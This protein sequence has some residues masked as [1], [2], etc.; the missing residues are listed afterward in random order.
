MK[1]VI[2]QIILMTLIASLL[3]ACSDGGTSTSAAPESIPRTPIS[4]EDFVLTQQNSL[5]VNGE[6]Q[7]NVQLNNLAADDV[8][9]VTA[10]SDDA[11]NGKLTLTPF[12]TILNPND[13]SASFVL[14]VKDLGVSAAPTIEVSITTSG[15]Q[16]M[17]QS[18]TLQWNN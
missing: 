16:S 7:V 15:N 6:T 9:Y 8:V 14:E 3:T 13:G 4:P 2:Q 10:S 17:S 12:K 5:A 18:Q 11:E 1:N